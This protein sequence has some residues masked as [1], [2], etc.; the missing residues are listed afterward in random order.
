MTHHVSALMALVGFVAATPLHAAAADGKAVYQKNCAACHQASGK[1][2]PGA[3]P[4]LAGNSLVQGPAR[5]PATVLLK[6][7]GGM[8][9]FSQ[10]LNDGDIAA[11]LTYARS[12]WGNQS[13][14]I[15]EGDV[16]ALRTE[17]SAEVFSAGQLSNK[18]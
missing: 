18:H 14:A 12:S 13:P 7:R 10:S 8:P 3:F 6:G 1:G 2:I 4:A 9:D 16:S 17:I 5:E 15:A 11:V